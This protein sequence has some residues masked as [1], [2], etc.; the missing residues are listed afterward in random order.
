MNV[1]PK[2]VYTARA[3][4]AK[5]V[6]KFHPRDAVSVIINIELLR[7]EGVLIHYE[8]QSDWTPFRLYMTSPEQLDLL[9]RWGRGEV[10]LDDTFSTNQYKFQLSTLLVRRREEST[11]GRT[12]TR[13][14]QSCAV[15]VGAGEDESKGGRGFPVAF[16]VHQSKNAVEYTRFLNW[17]D[18]Q[19]QIHLQQHTRLGN[20]SAPDYILQDD[21]PAQMKGVEASRW[22]ESSASTILCAFHYCKTWFKAIFPCKPVPSDDDVR[23]KKSTTQEGQLQNKHELWESL[24]PTADCPAVWHRQ[25]GTPPHASR[26]ISE[27]FNSRF[28]RSSAGM[29][30]SAQRRKLAKPAARSCS[31]G[32]PRHFLSESCRMHR[33]AVSNV[34]LRTPDSVVAR[35][36]WGGWGG[37]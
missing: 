5:D 11:P 8:E 34:L 23:K 20:Y 30:S 26:S 22:G 16:A 12:P 15:G 4:L 13:G 35:G 2:D 31:P 25:H 7:K 10:Q 36:G 37:G 24:K 19:L 3:L 14:A 29:H 28:S 27:A 6:Y 9:A 21:C 17:V 33:A 1:T 32:R 18:E